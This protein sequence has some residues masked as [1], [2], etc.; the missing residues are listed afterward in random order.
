MLGLRL[1]LGLRL[2]L[3]SAKVEVLLNT[4]G[5]IY[6]NYKI[7]RHFCHQ[8]P[9]SGIGSSPFS[10]IASKRFL[11]GCDVSWSIHQWRHWTSIWESEKRPYIWELD[12]DLR[13][14]CR[15]ETGRRSESYI[16]INKIL[17]PNH[18]KTS[19]KLITNWNASI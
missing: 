18:Y 14:G 2:G 11:N 4:I 15:L 10:I 17:Y 6:S 7:P 8:E 19:T 16:Y 12:A 5:F 3:E 13:I 1:R 9:P